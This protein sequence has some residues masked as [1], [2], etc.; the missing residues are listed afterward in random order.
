MS[1]AN[2][3]DANISGVNMY[4][5]NIS[6]ANTHS[7]SSK[8]FISRQANN[9]LTNGLNNGLDVSNGEPINML[10]F[11]Y[12]SYDTFGEKILH[13]INLKR[14]YEFEHSSNPWCLLCSDTSIFASLIRVACDTDESV[15]Y[16]YDSFPQTK[17]GAFIINIRGIDY[18]IHRHEILKLWNDLS[19]S[20]INE[21]KAHF[22]KENEELTN[23][24]V[25]KAVN[26]F[27]SLLRIDCTNNTLIF[28][29]PDQQ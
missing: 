5:V 8:M 14:F 9:G 20:Y 28:E 29:L 12:E 6:G 2:M 23:T 21:Y 15:R 13:T 17:Y 25:N 3:S 26:M 1:D 24:S 27:K 16:V 11:R 18:I 7:K 4:D 22:K 10:S 19:I